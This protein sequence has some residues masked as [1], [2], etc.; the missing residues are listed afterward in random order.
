[1]T[2]ARLRDFRPRF[3]YYSD[4]VRAGRVTIWDRLG[5]FSPVECA[6]GDADRM[7]KALNN[8]DRRDEL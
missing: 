7:C 5:E 8:I 2:V 4:C 3:H 6:E 1:M